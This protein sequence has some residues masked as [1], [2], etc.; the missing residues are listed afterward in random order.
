M[1]ALLAVSLGLGLAIG[2]ASGGTLRGLSNVRLRATPL[3]AL[4]LVAGL[5]PLAIEIA[6]EPRRWIQ[7]ATN[8]GVLIFLG[9][10]AR[11][12]RGSLR[13]GLGLIAAGWAMN[14]AVITAN[15]G[16]PLSLWAWGHSG[17][18]GTPTPG[19]GGFF[20]IVLAGPGTVLRPL[21]DVIP[22]RALS[23]VVSIGDVVLVAGIAA[24]IS[25]AMRTAP[26]AAAE[27]TSAREVR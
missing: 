27:T 10:N 18:T 19:E 2:A 26:R 9:V 4:S 23:Q 5:A 22:V 25:A 12:L 6:A 15:K 16:M 1:F 7:M 17:Q 3:L 14:F 13:V 24:V 11:G 21:G 8:L 20:K